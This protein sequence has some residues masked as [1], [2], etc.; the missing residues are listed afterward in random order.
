MMA[1]E[2]SDVKRAFEALSQKKKVYDQLWHY[3][4]GLQ[5]LVYSND[6][7]KEV[8]KNINARFRQNWCSVVVDS[9]IER[10]EFKQFSVINDEAAT[11]TLNDWWVTSEMELDADDVEL[12]AIV[13]GESFVMVW[14]GMDGVLEAYYN[15]SRM[16]HVFYQAEN[17]RQMEMVAKWWTA[18]DGTARLTLYY[19]ERLEYYS[20]SKKAEEISSAD[21]FQPLLINANDEGS[22]VAEN[23]FGQITWFHFRRERRAIKSELSPAILDT[24]D[25][26]NKLFADMMVAAE[27]G[28]FKQRYIIS[29]ADVGTLK[30]AP[31]EIWDLPAGDGLSQPTTVGEFA[32]TNLSNFMDAMERL[33][34]SI[35]KTTRTPLYYFDLGK[36]ADP[37]GETLMAMDAPLV[38]K[39]QN[40]IKRFQREWERL[41]R[42][43]APYLLLD[44]DNI[45]AVYGDPRT[46]QPLTEAQTR[47]TNVESGIPLTT[48]LRR[49]GWTPQEMAQMEA[50]KQAESSA[51]QQ[52][53]GVAL[54]NAQRQFNQ[55]ANGVNADAT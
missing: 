15:D 30:N 16:V 5:P 27:Y 38:K 28:A 54:L 32:E 12:C 25:A 1:N 39:V 49:E 37:S 18:A 7:L 9:V 29:A 19:P 17:P 33:A 6:R 26:V 21:A 43:V 2:T 48:I 45:Q 40:Y 53:L 44:G 22:Y 8:F 35:G 11:E 13:T 47:K 4:D 55:P 14:P 51:Q 36:R 50:D 42:F 24:Q 46:I 41:G 3:Y 20:S 23:P 52:T 10:L 31:N 34:A